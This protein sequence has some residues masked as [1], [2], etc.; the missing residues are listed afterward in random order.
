MSFY[1][2]ENITERLSELITTMQPYF[3]ST[4]GTYYSDALFFIS[5]GLHL[6]APISQEQ[7]IILDVDT[8]LKADIALLNKEF[9]K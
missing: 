5:L 6:I 3:T 4:P 2:I 9:D 7:A 8:K 1:N